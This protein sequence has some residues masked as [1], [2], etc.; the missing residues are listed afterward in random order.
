MRSCP[1]PPQSSGVTLENLFATMRGESFANAKY[2]AYG[3]KARATGQ[4]RLKRLWFRTADVELLEHFAEAATLAGLVRD[5]ATNLRDAIQ[6]EISEATTIYVGY[7]RDAWTAGDRAAA[8]LF[9]EL[10][11]D[12]AGHAAAFVAALQDLELP[13]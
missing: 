5:T 1:G 11:R 8:R 4:P 7:A 13:R 10:A 2:M 9:A 3:L 12:E 6:G